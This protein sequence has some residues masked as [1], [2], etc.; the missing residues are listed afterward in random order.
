MPLMRF[1]HLTFGLEIP[2]F[3]FKLPKF[4]PIKFRPL[5]I[6]PPL[7]N[8]SSVVDFDNAYSNE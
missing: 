4:D 2:D 7:D 1:D 3:V 5:S 6:N 8:D